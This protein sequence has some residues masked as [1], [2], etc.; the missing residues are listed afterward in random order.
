MKSDSFPNHPVL[1]D[2]LQRPGQPLGKRCFVPRCRQAW[3]YPRPHAA[4]AR[5]GATH[6]SVFKTLQHGHVSVRARRHAAPPGCLW[7]ASR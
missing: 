4:V 1:H 3:S 7:G 2:P 5:P 6:G